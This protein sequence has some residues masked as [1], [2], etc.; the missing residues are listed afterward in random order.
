VARGRT[1]RGELHNEA[2]STARLIIRS[3]SLNC[4]ASLCSPLAMDRP[5]SETRS[6]RDA[7]LGLLRRIELSRRYDPL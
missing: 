2:S 7:P 4:F 3:S 5:K 1:A 6:E